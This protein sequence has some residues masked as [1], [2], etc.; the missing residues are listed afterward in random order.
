MNVVHREDQQLREHALL[1]P[2]EDKSD[3]SEGRAR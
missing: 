3:E 2:D 1:S